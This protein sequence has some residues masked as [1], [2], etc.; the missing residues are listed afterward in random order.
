MPKARGAQRRRL[1]FLCGAVPVLVTAVLGV[2]RPSLFARLDDSVYDILL[3]STPAKGP[4]QRVAIVDVDNR[5]LS[6]IGQWPWRRD[7]VGRLITRLRNAG[8]SAIALDIIFAEPDRDGLEPGDPGD[9]G[10]PGNYVRR[11]AD[12]TATPPD[13]ALA[14]VLREGRVI[15]GYG[16][17]FDAAPPVPSACV[18]H[19]IGIA[20][21]SL[22]TRRDTS[23]SFARRVPCATC[24]CWPKPPPRRVF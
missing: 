8:A 16:L 21:F 7:V 13:A 24:R 5:S 3:R 4:G 14:G 6:T 15:L 11:S 19:P 17:T 2:F 22:P 9:P 20:T 10:N 12:D 1:V 18:L 23:R